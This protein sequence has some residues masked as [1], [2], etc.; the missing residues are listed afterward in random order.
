M[1]NIL[2]YSKDYSNEDDDNC[3]VCLNNFENG[4][5][6]RKFKCEHYFHKLCID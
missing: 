1:N 3:V 5:E 6:I 4:E 2:N